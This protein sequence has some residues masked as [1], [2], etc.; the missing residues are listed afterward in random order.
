[1]NVNTIND[2]I[3]TA[4][5]R[6]ARARAELADAAFERA[7]D[8]LGEARDAIGEAAMEFELADVP[9][10]AEISDI[11]RGIAELRK[12]THHG[13]A[14]SR[15]EDA[16]RRARALLT[17]DDFDGA[18]GE[19]KA[20]RAH[21]AQAHAALPGL[22]WA[23]A[24]A[25]KPAGTAVTGAGLAAAL[26]GGRI[27]FSREHLRAFE[28][29]ASLQGDSYIRVGEEYFCIVAADGSI[30][31]QEYMDKL[32]LFHQEADEAME[33]ASQVAA[34][35]AALAAARSKLSSGDIEGAKEERAT[36]V[37]AYQEA[38]ADKR[39]ELV[40]MN[41]QIVEAERRVVV[42][43]G[44]AAM[45][46]ARACLDRD[47]F[48]GARAARL[49]AA[50][51]FD[52][53]GEHGKLQCAR[54]LATEI[55]GAEMQTYLAECDLIIQSAQDN[56]VGGDD[57]E[58]AKD[59]RARAAGVLHEAER[60]AKALLEADGGEMQELLNRIAALAAEH[61]PCMEL[62][63]SLKAKESRLRTE[64]AV[65]EDELREGFELQASVAGREELVKLK[66]RLALAQEGQHAC[67][68]ALA[69]ALEERK[70][71]SAVSA[72][73]RQELA[74]V[75]ERKKRVQEAI[76]L[77]GKALGDIDEDVAAAR[78][79]LY[80]TG[81]LDQTEDDKET[82]TQAAHIF[83]EGLA[84]A[85]S[86]GMRADLLFGRCDALSR[87]KRFEE[88]LRDAEARSKVR[89]LSARSFDCKATALRGLER[90]VEAMDAQKLADS[91]RLLASEP[92][93]VAFQKAVRANF[94]TVLVS[95]FAP[96]ESDRPVRREDF[97][98][99]QTLARK[100]LNDRSPSPTRLQGRQ[101]VPRPS[102]KQADA[103]RHKAPSYEFFMVTKRDPSMAVKRG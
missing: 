58:G 50:V 34:G 65:V 49:A 14:V 62:V 89:P 100:V 24:G 57:I 26:A 52:K 72:A 16:L 46:K 53:S 74:V 2:G 7:L 31:E 86:V 77:R 75:E 96:P 30:V 37:Y 32:A 78:S 4:R 38:K 20:A 28:L 73:V 45:V 102:P 71:Q 19:A 25:A 54:G 23:A 6:L 82:C 10:V 70:A 3:K 103:A 83:G 97:E 69:T 60:C 63:D 87:L 67:R 43:E 44:D 99:K 79:L 51:A 40:W 17:D 95:E 61:A 29:S 27:E 98:D 9:V 18:L 48:V 13:S 12:E 80:G 94:S 22:R 81:L 76:A 33:R 42:A 85:T 92:E 1:M 55:A 64:I 5:E 15:G 59:E 56:L 36:A 93:N 66:A 8:V 41:D 68:A 39:A 91:L 88:A 11:E 35:D 101:R 90:S 21:F 47:E 84:H